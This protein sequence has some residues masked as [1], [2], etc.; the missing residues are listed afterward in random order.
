[1]TRMT[2]RERFIA[3]LR[4]QEPDVVPHFDGVDPKVM[5]AI[6]PGGSHEEFVEYL[7]I[8]AIGSLDKSYSWGYET[9]DAA[10]NIKRD[11]WGA[12]VQFGAEVGGHP[13]APAINC[14]EDLDRY[15]PPDP[16]EPWRYDYLNRLLK[17]FKGE[18]AVFAH[19]TDVFNIASDWLLGA[20]KYYQYMIM[21]PDLVDRANEIA[22]N[23][24]LGYL[25]NCLELG[26]DFV[27]ITGDFA[28]T[29]GPFVSPK[30][31]RRFMTPALKKQVDLVHRAGVPVLKHTDGNIWKILDDLV[32]TGIDGLHPIDPMSGMDLGEVKERYGD[33][34]CLAGNV[35]CGPTLSWGTVE[36]VRQEVKSCIRKAGHGG[37]YICM[38]SNSVHSGVKPENY[39]A[40]VRAIREFGQYPLDLD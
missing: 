8:D 9:V 6:L 35:N 10:K 39:V 28:M 13:V 19:A 26:V 32:D 17:R 2:S 33:R 30:H 4:G 1:M 27:F 5:N 20:E 34:L 38:S 22:L 3:A 24:N 40:M 14:E 29:K 37:G 25:K 7:D 11:H 16:D 15:V 12:L 23:Y 31:T 36:E 18:R 21:K